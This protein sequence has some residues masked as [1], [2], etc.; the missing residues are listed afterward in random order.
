MSSLLSTAIAELITESLT[1]SPDRL[2]RFHVDESIPIVE[3][4]NQVS[5]HSINIVV[6]LLDPDSFS[7]FIDVDFAVETNPKI[8]TK[9]RNDLSSNSGKNSS[10]P[11]LILIGDRKGQDYDGLTRLT[12]LGL[13][14]L[15]VRWRELLISDLSV[16]FQNEDLRIRKTAV[17]SVTA[18]ASNRIFTIEAANEFL[19]NTVYDPSP[20]M[21]Q[22]K[23]WMLELI[24]DESL[25]Q[26]SSFLSRMQFN[27]DLIDTL[28]RDYEENGNKYRKLSSSPNPK[29]NS[30]AKYLETSDEQD[31]KNSE[32]TA[33]L[34]ALKTPV[35]PP[36]EKMLELI[37][38]LGVRNLENRNHALTETER[39]LTH[40]VLRDSAIIFEGSDPQEYR[41]KVTGDEKFVEQWQNS[42]APSSSD[43]SDQL[44]AVLETINQEDIRSDTPV[45]EFAY[46]NTLSSFIKSDF[47]DDYFN[48]R[49]EIIE[50]S[51]LLTANSDEVLSLFVASKLVFETANNLSLIHI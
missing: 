1:S 16:N 22:K 11:S 28:G 21:V 30:F 9:L 43:N 3:A 35:K 27:S 44:V 37:E 29:V 45:T 13:P 26:H 15:I 5:E 2:V 18:S 51:H 42:L 33:I 36:S 23:L 20:E 46:R 12:S 17:S 38:L 24:P 10:L 32:L 34:E 14:E 48:K 25:V 50:I 6:G 31:L 47:I 49:K 7:D 41:L 8:L 39:F 40:N 19:L 4:L